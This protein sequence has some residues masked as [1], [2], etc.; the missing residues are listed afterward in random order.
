MR[1]IALCG[2][3]LL[4]FF[5]FFSLPAHADDLTVLTAASY[6][7]ERE[8]KLPGGWWMYSFKMSVNNK[9]KFPLANVCGKVKS[10][11]S[12][13]KVIDPEVCFPDIPAGGS[14]AS[15]GTFTIWTGSRLKASPSNLSWTYSS[16]RITAD[17]SLLAIQQG[18]PYN[19]LSYYVTLSTSAPKPYYV[20]F[21]Q[22]VP[23]GITATEVPRGWETNRTTTWLVTEQITA[24]AGMTAEIRVKAWILNTLQ[25]AEVTVPVS[26]SATTPP[27]T[28]GTLGS[29]P[30][31][32]HPNTSTDVRFTISM[33]GSSLPESLIL[34]QQVSG[35]WANIGTLT[36]NGQNGDTKAG[37]AIYGGIAP[38]TAP[39]GILVF[40]AF[41]STGV[42]DPYTLTVTPF[43]IGPAPTLPAAVITTPSGQKVVGNRL[44]IRFLPGTDAATIATI[45][46]SINGAVVGFLGSIGYYHVEIPSTDQAALYAALATLKA[47]PSVL[48]AQPDFVGDVSSFNFT[49]KD[50][51]YDVNG[52]SDPGADHPGQWGMKAI[53]AD[54][55]WPLSSGQG[56]KVAVLDYGVDPTH[57]EFDTRVTTCIIAT[58]G[59]GDHSLNCPADATPI[60]NLLREGAGHG[61]K[62]A[63]IIGAKGNNGAGI[64]G[65]AWDSEI[66]SIKVCTAGVGCPTSLVNYGVSAAFT[67]KNARIINL[68]L[69]TTRESYTGGQCISPTSTG[70]DQALAS[71]VQAV[72]S[73]ALIVVAAGN[74]NTGEAQNTC[75]TYPAAYPGALAVGATMSDGT[76]KTNSKRGDWVHLAAPGSQIWT[77]T[78]MDTNPPYGYGNDTSIA[79][80]HVAGAAALL[81]AKHPQWSPN[82]IRSR[83]LLSAQQPNTIDVSYGLL[84]AYALLDPYAPGSLDTSFGNGGVVTHNN[85]AG[86]NSWDYGHSAVLDSQSRI[87]VTGSSSNTAGNLDMTIWR[88]LPT[89]ALDTT[90][91]GT[92]YVVHNNAAGGNSDDS[93]QSIALDSTGR[94]LVAGWS[95]NTAGS[96][97]MAIWRYNLNGTLD[98]TFGGTGYVVQSNTAGG[99][100]YDTGLSMALD[101]SSRILVTGYSYNSTTGNFDMAIWRYNLNG[102]LDTTFGGTGYV[103]HNNG[104]GGN[105]DDY[106]ISTALDSSGR[107]LV[108][109]YSYNNTAG[110]S[111]MVVWRYLPNGTLDQSFGNGKGFVVHNNAVGGNS[112]DYGHSIALDSSGRILVTGYSTMSKPAT[113]DM[114][115]W[116]YLPDGTLD[117]T[118]GGTGY[119]FHNNAAGGNSTDV[120]YL[121]AVDSSGRILVTGY[122]MNAGGNADTV[123]WRYLPNGTL[124][125]TFGNGGVVVQNNAA[126]GNGDDFGISIVFD[127]TGRILVTGSSYNTAGNSDMT[128]W[129]C[130]P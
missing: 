19:T 41:S 95:R 100:G 110:N 38:L 91:G 8:L 90:F 92:G 18:A 36:D 114:V 107:I 33:N 65:M 6:S 99:V 125:P 49:N 40:R 64:A 127:P 69:W 96:Y 103:V 27:P 108:T 89:G 22:W 25:E 74:Y 32:L 55:A 52:P 130:L 46:G 120:G 86:G 79:A 15:R 93:G 7:R 2:L 34:Q 104:A 45:L 53:G 73:D 109:G 4:L 106:G 116:R 62:V 126:G 3:A 48:A 12:S 20:L 29:W 51:Y 70:D 31:A 13:V 21:H 60:I 63:G 71:A 30:S 77:L 72:S 35:T 123:I 98:T 39:E 59:N 87:L 43:P 128:I 17:P 42:S 85:A 26:V 11:S 117:T 37:D 16:L 50:P 9:G 1:R 118:F 115:A 80:P 81:W 28:L 44:L 105:S 97:D 78:P 129:R 122:S 112:G 56:A 24:S 113:P 54:N 84:D 111:D 102:T 23:E 61:T 121:I 47:S 124:D 5:S 94:I 67:E 57:P 68:S 88:Y 76:L 14:A 82:T 58:D 66:I 119:V 83:L 10:T 101:S 75:K